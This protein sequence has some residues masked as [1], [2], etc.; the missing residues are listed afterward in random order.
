V[1]DMV[2]ILDSEDYR[3]SSGEPFIR[4]NNDAEAFIHV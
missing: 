3:R 4:S 2:M 1:H